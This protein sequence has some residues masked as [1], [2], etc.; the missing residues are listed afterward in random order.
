[1][2]FQRL[3]NFLSKFS[4]ALSSRSK[5]SEDR[6]SKILKEIFPS[7]RFTAKIKNKTLIVSASATYQNELFLKREEILEKLREELG[8]GSPREISF[9]IL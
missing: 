7:G 5:A 4:Q 2:P 9:R 8:T 6:I 3:N 1:M